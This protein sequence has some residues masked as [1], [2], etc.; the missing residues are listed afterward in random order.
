MGHISFMCVYPCNSHQFVNFPT[1]IGLEVVARIRA[2]LKLWHFFGIKEIFSRGL[3]LLPSC[4][5][6]VIQ[7]FVSMFTSNPH[8]LKYWSVSK[9]ETAVIILNIVLSNCLS[10]VIF[11]T[12]L[13][14]VQ[15]SCIL[16]PEIFL[17][18][19]EVSHPK[20]IIKVRINIFTEWSF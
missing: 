9:S 10:A 17:K 3:L 16:F 11:F 8:Y 13:Q 7:L 18:C 20:S 2:L 6:A 5:R 4:Y 19:Q 15:L 14:W 12:T 1:G